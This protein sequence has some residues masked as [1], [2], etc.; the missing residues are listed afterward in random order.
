MPQDWWSKLLTGVGASVAFL[1]AVS[2]FIGML[3][4]LK[5]YAPFVGVVGLALAAFN[6]A[7]LTPLPG[8][9]VVTVIAAMGGL[10]A[11]VGGASGVLSPDVAGTV[12]AVGAGLL[13]FTK[14]LLPA[15]D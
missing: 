11:V 8:G 1:S 12:A 15:H 14:S 6:K 7:L 4:P 13:A 5:P 2:P 9:K 10:L 3:G